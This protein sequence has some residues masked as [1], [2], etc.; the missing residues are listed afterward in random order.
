MEPG[1]IDRKP[2]DLKARPSV[3]RLFLLTE[4]SLQL[5]GR[6]GGAIIKDEGHGLYLPTQGFGNDVLLHKDLEIDKAFALSAGAIDQAIGDRDSGQQ[7]AGAPTPI[8]RLVQHRPT[9]RRQ[10]PG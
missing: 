2:E 9:R 1:G 8:A 10:A 5:F 6:V 3:T 4:P 7:M